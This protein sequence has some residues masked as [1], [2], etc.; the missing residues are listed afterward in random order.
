[1]IF[2]KAVSIS[3]SLNLPGEFSVKG[4]LLQ[5]YLGASRAERF[6]VFINAL[7]CDAPSYILGY[8]KI[9]II[10]LSRVFKKFQNV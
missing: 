2:C 1:M 5:Q 4:F 3:D 6:T 8:V 7:A 10:A 9:I